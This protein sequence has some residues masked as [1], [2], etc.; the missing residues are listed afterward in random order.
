MLS[1]SLASPALATDGGN[2][3]IKG[4][5]VNRTEGGS[6]VAAQDVTLKVHL[7]GEEIDSSSTQTDSGGN[8]TFEGLSTAPE[9]T[10]EASLDYQLAEYYSDWLVFAEGETVITAE[11]VVYDSTTADDAIRVEMAHTVIYTDPENLWVEEYYL[12]INDSDR[13]YIGPDELVEGDVRRTL[14]FILPAE[15]LNLQPAG[16]LMQ[17]CIYGTEDGFTDSMPVLPGGKEIAFSYII[18]YGP[19]VHAFAQKLDYPVIQYNL[20]VQGV[21]SKI[22]SGQLTPNE[23]LNIEGILFSLFTGADFASGE[24]IVFE[25]SGLANSD[26]QNLV[27]WVVL[28]LV[29]LFIG[30]GFFFFRRRKKVPP[31]RAEVDPEQLRQRLMVELARLDDAFENGNMDE[32]EYQ[33]LRA[34]KKAQVLSLVQRAKEK[35]GSS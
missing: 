30:F 12:F 9:Y 32:R 24:T 8:F 2:G 4:Q 18:N 34:D 31:V 7:N 14:R 19:K 16:E 3:T 26:D 28:V 11:V 1:L 5:V 6:S 17:C 23:P 20:V 15:A 13:T 35:S 33:R 25:L 21:D 10:Y 29:A 22:D 27:L